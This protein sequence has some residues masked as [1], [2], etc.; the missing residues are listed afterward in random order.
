MPEKVYLL[1]FIFKRFKEI[2]IYLPIIEPAA[3]AS[4]TYK[5]LLVG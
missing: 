3:N 5:G 4:T 1:F 2:F